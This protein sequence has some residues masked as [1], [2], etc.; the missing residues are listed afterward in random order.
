MLPEAYTPFVEPFAFILGLV[1]GSFYNVCIV[2]YGSGESIVVPSSK[3]PA[4]GHHLSWWENIPVLSFFLLRACCRECRKPISWRYPVVEIVSGL[5]AWALADAFGA[6]PAFLFHMVLGGIL[7]VA[8]FIDFEHYILPDF[9]T[10]PGAALAFLGAVFVMDMPWQTSLIGAA[11]GAGTFRLLQLAYR[12]FRGMEGLG[13]GDVKLMLLLGALAGW[14]GLPVV[15]TWG[16]MSALVA[17]L[18]YMARA[19]GEDR[20]RVMIPFGPFL[21]FGGMLYVLYGAR[22]WNW[23]L[24]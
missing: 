4:C 20:L 10:L 15:I 3:C 23:Y 19:R 6:S 13:T 22:F 5:W 24:G 16:A 12:R 9:L 2:R 11:V 21:S 14:K 8:S 7:I 18:I 17:S 1:L